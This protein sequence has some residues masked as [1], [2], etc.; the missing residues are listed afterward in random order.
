MRPSLLL[1]VALLVVKTAVGAVATRLLKRSLQVSILSGLSLAQVGEF[2]FVL[3]TVGVSHG[4]LRPEAHQV[5]IGASV[6]S[7]LAAPFVIA[8]ARPLAEL[9]RRRIPPEGRGCRP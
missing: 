3:A 9:A 7:M 6:M 8:S 4:L 1:L 5:F 2:S